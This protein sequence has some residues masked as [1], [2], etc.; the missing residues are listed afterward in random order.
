M[1]EDKPAGSGNRD[2]GLS[3]DEDLC[4]DLLHDLLPPQEREALLNRMAADCDLEARFRRLV[5]EHERLRATRR[6]ERLPTGDLVVTS[7]D[8]APAGRQ[9][10]WQGAARRTSRAGWLV[11]L[12]RHRGLALTS[13]L[14]AAAALLVLTVLPREQTPHSVSLLRPLPA[15]EEDLQVRS[16]ETT[17]L[18]PELVAGLQAYSDQDYRDASRRL[19]K[20]R[21]EGPLETVRQLYLGSALAQQAHWEQ[22][23]TVLGAA[24]TAPLPD[25]WGSEARWTLAI[26][27][28]E[29]GNQ[30]RA[31]SLLQLLAAEPGEVGARAQALLDQRQ[32]QAP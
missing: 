28:A 22:V 32:R 25:P 18:D 3:R 30:V 16:A 13:G 10:A 12:N 27:L 20:A 15:Y 26:A 1:N 24:A 31:D 11:R 5:S 4:I 14:A 29:T 6:L 9:P 23:V 19:Q 7:L 17:Q 8:I 21:S 2:L